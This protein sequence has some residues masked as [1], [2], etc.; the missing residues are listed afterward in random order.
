MLNLILFGPPGA[1]KGTQAQKIIDKYGLIQLS[2]GDMLRSQIAAKTELGLEAQKIMAN[3]DL[4]SDEIVVGMIKSIVH[5]NKGAK[6][7]IFDGFPRTVKQ[8]EALNEL[9]AE[10]DEEIAQLILLDVEDEEL[11]ARLLNRGK[12]SGRA[13]DQDVSIIENRI[14]VFKEQTTPVMNHY[15]EKG[16]SASIEGVGT[17]DDIFERLS[18]AIDNIND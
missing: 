15:K 13:D 9:L 8:A 12:D 4:V 18:A 3:G 7:Y 10:I 16:K 11:K 2:T 5:A 1:G 6:G 17:I 14:K